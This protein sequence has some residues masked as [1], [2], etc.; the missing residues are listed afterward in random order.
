M[1][2]FGERKLKRKPKTM[3]PIEPL[4]DDF[5]RLPDGRWRL[6]PKEEETEA[7][8]VRQRIGRTSRMRTESF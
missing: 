8:T 2:Q 1:T 5:G 4:P 6:R 7:A 3:E